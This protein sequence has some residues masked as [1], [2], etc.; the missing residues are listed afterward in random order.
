MKKIY[1]ICIYLVICF[2]NNAK[3]QSS[4]VTDTL[5]Y[6]NT[7]I[8]NKAS[9][10]GKP[11]SILMND[12]QIQIKYFFPFSNLHHDQTKETS[13]EFSFYFPPTAEEIH[14]TYPSLEIFW[15]THLDATKT[16]ALYTQYRALGWAPE[17]ATFYSSGI[18]KDI[19]IVQ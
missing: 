11:F 17:V 10:V 9:Y 1:F 3:A 12:L 18:I 5:N 4:P 14:L 2:A 13:T 7:I 6:L 16:R 15:Q 19:R 8:A